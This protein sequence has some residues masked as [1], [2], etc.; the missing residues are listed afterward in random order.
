MPEQFVSETVELVVVVHGGI[1]SWAED[2]ALGRIEHDAFQCR[3]E[4][5]DEGEKKWATYGIQRESC[6]FGTHL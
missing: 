2:H 1:T 4:E 5:N 6:M 3:D